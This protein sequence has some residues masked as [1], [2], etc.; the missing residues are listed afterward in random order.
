[1]KRIFNFFLRKC[2]KIRNKVTENR[3]KNLENKASREKVL[4]YVTIFLKMNLLKEA[5]A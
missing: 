3:R 5:V 1:M 2:K 4:A